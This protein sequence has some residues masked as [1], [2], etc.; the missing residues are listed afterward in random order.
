MWPMV[1]G[2]FIMFLGAL[3]DGV[4]ISRF[5]GTESMAAFGLFQPLQ[6]FVMIISQIFATGV[7]A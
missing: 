5:L 3:V 7:Q 6:L 4:L 1:A 2:Q